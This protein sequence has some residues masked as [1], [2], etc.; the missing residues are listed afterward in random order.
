MTA[1]PARPGRIIT[2]PD[3]AAPGRISTPPDPAAPGRGC[4]LRYRYRPE[5][6]AAAP[7]REAEVLY[8]IGGLYGNLPALAAIEAMAAA[9][10]APVRLHFNGDFHWFD[11]DDTEFRAISERVLRHDAT[12]GNVEAEFV[13]DDGAAG[14][15]CAYPASVDEDTVDR[16]NAIHAQLA[17]TAHRH[18]DLLARLSPLSM[19]ARYRVGDAGVA[20]VHGDCHSLSGWSFDVD[21]LDDTAP[22]DAALAATCCEVIASSHTCLPV[23]RRRP[24]GVLA[25]NGAAGMANFAGDLRGIITRIATASGPHPALYGTTVGKVCVEALAVDIDQQDWQ[26]RFLADWPPGSPA[27]A[28]YWQR[29]SRGTAHAIERARP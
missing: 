20:V 11:V 9:E 5:D 16:S 19:F 24:R 18:P 17:E 10:R 29:I 14:C 13:A 26:R 1:D 4:P 7:Q 3:P 15:G 6:I 23:M 28:S 8:V 2:P 27:H 12:L 21:A 25:N 22:L